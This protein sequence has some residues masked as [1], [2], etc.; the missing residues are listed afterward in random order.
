[1]ARDPREAV[2]HAKGDGAELAPDPTLG[3]AAHNH[4]ACVSRVLARVGDLCAAQ[5]LRLTPTRRRTLELLLESHT[6]LGAYDVLRRLQEDG[7]GAQ[8]PAAYRAL[9]FLVEHG[10]AHRIERL[11]AFVACMHPGAGHVPAFMICRH[12]RAVAEAC[13][14]EN[15]PG[16]AN[17][18]AREA[19]AAGF[20]IERRVLEAEGV[21]A[22][23]R[24]DAGSGP[25]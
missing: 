12:C 1:M 24:D 3:I 11:N 25:S 9:D 22:G 23:C 5:Q 4:G 20:Q 2:T 7:L 16:L 18:L 15:A 8:P 21:C 14:P 13:L 6:A 17:A 19:E 10:F